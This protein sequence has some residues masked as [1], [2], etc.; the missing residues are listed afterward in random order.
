MHSGDSVF[1]VLEGIVITATENASEG[2]YIVL[3]HD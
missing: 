2:K 1:A 3:R